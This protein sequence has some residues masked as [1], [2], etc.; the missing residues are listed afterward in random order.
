[1]ATSRKAFSMGHPVVI[2]FVVIAVVAAMSLAAEVLKPLSL[3]V[4]LAFALS[5][6]ARFFE[7]RGLPRVPAVVLTVLIALGGL[8]GIGYVVV[9]QLNSLAVFGRESRRRELAPPGR[10]GQRIR[11]RLRQ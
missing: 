2:L 10:P 5:P 4:L 3:S 11:P 8:A 9:G 7:R 1:M 6:F